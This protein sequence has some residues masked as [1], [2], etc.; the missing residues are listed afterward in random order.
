[1]GEGQRVLGWSAEQKLTAKEG[2]GR[3]VGGS[4]ENCGWT[5]PADSESNEDCF[6]GWMTLWGPPRWFGG[7]TH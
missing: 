6:T 5:S 4:I 3:K 7:A 2:S 1:M